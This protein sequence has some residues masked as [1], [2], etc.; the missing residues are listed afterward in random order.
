MDVVNV[1][2]FI[3]YY[4]YYI[5]ATLKKLFASLENATTQ[6]EKDK[7]FS[8]LQV[9]VTNASIA[10]DECDFGTGLELGIDLFCSGLKELHSIALS[11]LTAAYTVLS[12]KEFAQIAEVNINFMY[13]LPKESEGFHIMS[14]VFTTQ[15]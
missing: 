9:V 6:E 14:I 3:I 1:I 2:T 5:T 4:V 12:R 7:V 8:D 13:L 10:V 15:N 11:N